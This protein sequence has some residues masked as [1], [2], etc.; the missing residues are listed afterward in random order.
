M[1]RFDVK[2]PSTTTT[3]TPAVYESNFLKYTTVA[4]DLDEEGR[5]Y[6]QAYIELGTFKG[7][8]KTGVMTVKPLWRR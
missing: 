3:W 4:G 8:I 2:T 1:V 5:Y 7:H 6:I